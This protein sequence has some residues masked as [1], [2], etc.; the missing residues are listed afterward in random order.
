MSSYFIEQTGT[1]KII[2]IE[3]KTIMQ[4]TTP[5]VW[6]GTKTDGSFADAGYYVIIVNNKKVTNITVIR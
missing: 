1:A 2:D 6:Y 4:L 5:A 3:G